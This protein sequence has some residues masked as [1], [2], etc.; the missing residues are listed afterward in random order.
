VFTAI[1]APALLGAV[2]GDEY[3]QFTPVVR[4]FA[5]YYII[6]AFSDVVVASLSANGRTRRVFGGHVAGA[7]ASLVC[8]W[9]LLRA[10]G[11]AGGVAGMIVAICVAVSVFVNLR[12]LRG[13]PASAE[14]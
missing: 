11:A 10:F 1:F 2:Y 13:G 8:G 4:L 9:L 6:L 5:L 14:A 3:R 7:V 12:S